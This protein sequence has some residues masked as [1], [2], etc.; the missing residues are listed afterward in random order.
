MKIAYKSIKNGVFYLL[1]LIFLSSF[2][3]LAYFS[4]LDIDIKSIYG[5]IFVSG[6]VFVLCSIFINKLII[7]AQNPCNLYLL[8]FLTYYSL[9]IVGFSTY[10]GYIEKWFWLLI[11][12]GSVIF[13][14]LGIQL[15]RLSIFYKKNIAEINKKYKPNKFIAYG[16]LCLSLIS[17]T[18]IV[19][20]HGL[21][22]INP[23]A[24]FFISA[25]L[26]YIVEFSIPVIIT[27]FC[28]RLVN[29]KV[30]YKIYLL[31]FSF[32]IV[33]LSLGY[34]NQPVL[35]ILGILLSVFFHAGYNWVLVKYK[36]LFSL[37][38]SLMC[39]FLGY[40]YLIRINNS[41]GRTLNWKDT[42]IEFDIFNPEIILSIIPLH[43]ASREGMGVTE[44]AIERLG[45]IES[46]VPSWTLFFQ[47]FFTMLPEYSLTSGRILGI[48]VNLKETS[49]LTP[50]LIGGVMISF[51]IV[52]VFLCFLVMGFIFKKLTNLYRKT[53]DPKW[54]SLLVVFCLYAIEL[55]NRGFFKPMYVFSV[56]IVFMISFGSN[57][58][59]SNKIKS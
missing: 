42:I 47:D 20:R 52:G 57:Y 3:F 38:V 16:I 4:N 21:V 39:F 6:F 26:S 48:V 25:K 36:K 35:L 19:A 28:Y 43:M 7:W 44:V 51:G 27:L 34:R 31:I 11:L 9:G 54:L 22:F 55:T 56:I 50:S 45:I 41:I 33:L 59:D 18:Y 32:F 17:A 12:L 8:F 58:Y 49:S 37:I 40:S 23:E 13:Y 15:G 29:G 14:F 10:R 46:Y 53:Q 24:R 30:G 5:L 1:I 2:L